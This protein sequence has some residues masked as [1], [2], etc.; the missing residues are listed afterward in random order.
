MIRFRTHM[1][2]SRGNC[3]QVDHEG[4]TLLLDC[5]FPRQRACNGVL[6]G[7]RGELLVLISHAHNDHL[8]NSALKALAKRQVP[9][10]AHWSVEEQIRY[11]Y[12]TNGKHSPRMSAFTDMPFQFGPFHIRP[13]PVRHAPGV[14]NLGFVIECGSGSSYRKIV[15]CT[16]LCEPDDIADELP[17]A[18]F[19][20]IESNHDLELL[21]LNWNY[22]SKFHLSNPRTGELLVKSCSGSRKAP[23]AILLGHLSQQRNIPELAVRT[24]HEA[25]LSRGMDLPCPISTAPAIC[26]S[27]VICID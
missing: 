19:I 16:D 13:V 10:R 25:F 17:D 24:I 5:G 27:T 3:I 7:I 1:S 21:R 20:Y 18:D 12:D 15:A 11:R 9:F 26:P 22:A 2:S 4:A 6:D 14:P 23:Q 8:S